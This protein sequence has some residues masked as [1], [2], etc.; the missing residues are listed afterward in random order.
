MSN[1]YLRVGKPKMVVNLLSLCGGIASG[2]IFQ[3]NA[4]PIVKD[5]GLRS[6]IASS[7]IAVSLY[8]S[9]LSVS[10]CIYNQRDRIET[11]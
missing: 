4:R 7:E 8:L 11:T 6:L 3:S 1:S 9:S 2:H 10:K 5:G